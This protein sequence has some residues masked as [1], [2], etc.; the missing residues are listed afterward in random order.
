VDPLADLLDRA[1][2][3]GAVFAR[4]TMRGEWGLGFDDDAP[5]SVH[6][7]LAGEAWLTRPGEPAVRV[8]AGQLALVRRGALTVAGSPGTPALPLARARE[9]WA[10]PGRP[11]CYASPGAGPATVL[12][13]GAY[14]FDGRLCERLL[15][16]VPDVAVIEAGMAGALGDALALLARELDGG[17]AGQQVLLDRLLDVV[18]VMAM[19]AWLDELGDEAPRWYAAARDP[20]VGQALRLLHGEP[21]RAWTVA[22][23]AGAVGLSR[24][25]LARR[26][27]AAV[28]EPPLAYLTAWRMSLA[29]ELLRDGATLGQVA[30]EVGYANEF[31]FAAA[32]KRS[33]G[34]P[35]GR[36][37]RDVA[38]A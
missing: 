24:A 20:E 12:V 14:A 27:T 21:A 15:D 10:V 4:S 28:G 6:A 29:E 8:R 31:A 26:F 35:P 19:R 1:R 38:V 33:R 11:R 9:R 30:A 34:V 36:W 7:V 2:A 22:G 16:A 23:L 18:F 25:A 5:L 3:R 32:F 13:C 37:R 17:D